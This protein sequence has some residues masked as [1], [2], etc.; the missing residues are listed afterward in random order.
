MELPEPRDTFIAQTSFV[1]PSGIGRDVEVNMNE[2]TYVSTIVL[3]RVAPGGSARMS[4]FSEFGWT[5]VANSHNRAVS[6]FCLSQRHV[7][8]SSNVSIATR[9]DQEPSADNVTCERA[10]KD[11]EKDIN[12]V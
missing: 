3:L 5:Y 4:I 8:S 2:L 10:R 1:F 9:A 6:G 11:T 7:M 12:R